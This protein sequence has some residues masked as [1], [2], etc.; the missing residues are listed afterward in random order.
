MTPEKRQRNVVYRLCGWTIFL[1]IAAI[2]VSEVLFLNKWSPFQTEWII[3]LAPV[4]W[5]EA[6]AVVAFGISWVIKGEFVL[7][8]GENMPV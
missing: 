2:A 1:C 4:Y 8:D 6:I 3:R 7:S 5:L